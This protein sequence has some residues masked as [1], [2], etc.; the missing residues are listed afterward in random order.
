MTLVSNAVKGYHHLQHYLY[1]PE[2]KHKFALAVNNLSRT[3]FAG[4]SATN[5]AYN[6][7]VTNDKDKLIKDINDLCTRLFGKEQ[8]DDV[9]AF[10]FLTSVARPYESYTDFEKSGST[11]YSM[12]LVDTLKL[13][14]M[15]IH[16]QK[17]VLENQLME[18]RNKLKNLEDVQR[19]EFNNLKWP[20]MD[21]IKE[22]YDDLQGR[23]INNA[24]NKA[25]KDRLLPVLKLY[26]DQN[27]DYLKNKSVL[28]EPALNNIGV[29][30]DTLRKII[31]ASEDSQ[32][33][34]NGHEIQNLKIQ[35]EL[36]E[37]HLGFVNKILTKEAL[38]EDI[39][40]LK[41]TIQQVTDFKPTEIS[42]QHKAKV[43][44]LLKKALTTGQRLL[45]SRYSNQ[46]LDYIDK[47]DEHLEIQHFFQNNKD[48]LELFND[49]IKE[50]E[51][52]PQAQA[53]HLERL[54]NELQVLEE[55]LEILNKPVEPPKVVTD[56]DKKVENEPS[57][58]PAPKK[59]SR[60]QRLFRTLGTTFTRLGN[61]LK[62]F[63]K[64]LF[65][66]N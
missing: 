59:V 23:T 48:E 60:L 62:Q 31:T 9:E 15:P 19:Q 29:S 21:K 14:Q 44:Q 18:Q 12:S 37:N 16:Q 4:A 38:Q 57:L 63:F 50:F 46:N 54:K 27:L 49:I 51:Q 5:K 61:W 17:Q 7:S 42:W 20:H 55:Q 53:K 26:I 40:E 33:A 6:Y 3:I 52:T 22:I 65:R 13:Q 58:P 32:Y 45:S 66:T 10:L 24:S 43:D 30:L 36:L 28:T 25:L 2:N 39:Q 11:L 8:H 56:P 47:V 35:I 41:N 1:Q 34:K 64:N